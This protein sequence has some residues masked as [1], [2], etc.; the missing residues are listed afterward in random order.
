MIDAGFEKVLVTKEDSGNDND[1]YFYRILI[2]NTI[3]I[4]SD[5]SD[6]VKNNDYHLHIYELNII[7]KLIEDY[8]TF[9]DF[10]KKLVKK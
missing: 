5:E 8:N 1:Y 3:L 9:I 10:I 2:N 7:I 6:K 4:S